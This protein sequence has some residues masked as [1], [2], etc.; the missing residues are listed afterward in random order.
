[1][2]RFR[3][4]LSLLLM[5][6]LFAP[7]IGRASVEFLCEMDGTVHRSCCCDEGMRGERSCSRVEA[8]DCC[9]LRP[10]AEHRATHSEASPSVAPILSEVAGAATSARLEAV[11]GQPPCRFRSAVGPPIFLRNCSILR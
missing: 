6:Q 4:L 3:S 1:M 10:G 9:A 5:V 7:A 11:G 8:A 2:G